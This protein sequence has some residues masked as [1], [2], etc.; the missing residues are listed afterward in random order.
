LAN[1]VLGDHRRA[2]ISAAVTLS[3]IDYPLGVAWDELVKLVGVSK[4]RYAYYH[5]ELVH[6]VEG[7]EVPL[8]LRVTW[9]LFHLRESL[10][11]D[12]GTPRRRSSRRGAADAAS[13]DRGLH[14]VW[15]AVHEATPLKPFPDFRAT[16]C[17]SCRS[18][19]SSA[20]PS[21]T[22]SRRASIVVGLS[23]R[24]PSCSRPFRRY[25]CRCGSIL[26]TSIRARS[27]LPSSW[28]AAPG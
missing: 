7:H 5:F 9:G 27:F 28:R 16:C 26:T 13:P 4:G 2:A 22:S 1:H 20:P 21:S 23:R 19:S 15:Y 10:W 24:S 18:S 3:L 8:P 11:P 12:L 17:R 25:Q 6:S 14:R